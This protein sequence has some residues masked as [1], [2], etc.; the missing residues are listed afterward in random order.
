MVEYNDMVIILDSV[1]RTAESMLASVMYECCGDVIGPIHMIAN[2]DKFNNT[3]K[4]IN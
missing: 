4:G 3:E 2:K 1:D